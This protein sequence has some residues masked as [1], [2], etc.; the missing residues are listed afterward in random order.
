MIFTKGISFMK[1]M[2]AILALCAFVS[3]SSAAL[4]FQTDSLSVEQGSTF[5]V[6][7]VT[8]D[9]DVAGYTLGALIIDGA[10]GW[11]NNTS[12]IGGTLNN[13]GALQTAN[14]YNLAVW[15]A[16]G[17]NSPGVLTAAGTVLFS[18]QITA[19]A[20]GTVINI[21]DYIGA[22]AGVGKT[23]SGATTTV[24]TVAQALDGISINVIPEPMTMALLG[25]GGLFIRRRRA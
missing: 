7:L 5:T 2:I 14:E 10:A 4:V 23:G 17:T 21:D 25:L 3:V 6:N 19:G 16:A 13:A 8:T 22:S 9:G 1:K 12:Y 11:S 24:N 15:K 20:A 18:I